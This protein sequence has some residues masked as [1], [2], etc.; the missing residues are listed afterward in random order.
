VAKYL[1]E[2]PDRYNHDEAYH[3]YKKAREE[4]IDMLIDMA[5]GIKKLLTPAQ[6]RVL[7]T[8]VVNFLDKRTLQGLRS[9][10]S[11]GNRF[12]GGGFGG[13]MR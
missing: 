10:T 1:S 11:G 7:P 6:I 4:S 3:R 13:G 5:P 9:G 8:A 2:L 12:A